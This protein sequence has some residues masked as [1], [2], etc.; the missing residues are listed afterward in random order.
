RQKFFR[1]KKP[2]RGT[3]LSFFGFWL[4]NRIP[5]LCAQKNQKNSADSKCANHSWRSRLEVIQKPV[6]SQNKLPKI[7]IT[8]SKRDPRYLQTTTNT[9]MCANA[10]GKW[11]LLDRSNARTYPR[12]VA[13]DSCQSKL[14]V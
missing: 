4:K 14:Q 6:Q 3:P 10:P 9:N 13:F 11:P 12:M 1:P 2:Q 8:Y 5:F 7:R